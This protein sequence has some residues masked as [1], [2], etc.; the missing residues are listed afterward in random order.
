VRVLIDSNILISALTFDGQVRKLLRRLLRSRKAVIAEEA[1]AE[2]RRKL[3]G[4]LVVPKTA[5]DDW[6]AYLRHKAEILPRQGHVPPLSRDPKDDWVLAAALVGHCDCILTG[7]A[8]LTVLKAHQGIPI[9]RPRDF[10]AFEDG[11]FQQRRLR[12]K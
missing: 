11:R 3:L 2:C 7:D 9:L 12:P 10:L 1:L 4:K 6:E 5:V 8:D